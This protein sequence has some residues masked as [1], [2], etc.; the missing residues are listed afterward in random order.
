[1]GR[2]ALL[3][4]IQELH[5]RLSGQK[6]P[7]CAMPDAR[8]ADSGLPVNLFTEKPFPLAVFPFLTEQASALRGL[9]ILFGEFFHELHQG[10]HAVEAH[11]VVNGSAAAADAAVAFQADETGLLGL[12]DELFLQFL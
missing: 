5:N 8:I 11:G 12:V 10:L 6:I 1:M 3:R 2:I 7:P 9:F 4:G